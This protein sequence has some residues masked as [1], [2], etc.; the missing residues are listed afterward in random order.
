MGYFKEYWK[1]GEGQTE[2]AYHSSSFH[3]YFEGYVEQKQT[4]PRTGRAK[5]VRIYTAPYRVRCASDAQWRAAK[6]GTM[7]LYLSSAV[8]LILAATVLELENPAK[9][10]QLFVAGSLVC[11]FFLLYILLR[12]LSAPRKMTIG[13]YRAVYPGLYRIA[14]A[15]AVFTSLAFPAR[16][17]NWILSGQPINLKC[18][19]GLL[20]IAASGTSMLCL[21]LRE[22]KA[23]YNIEDNEHAEEN[24]FQVQR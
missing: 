9:Y 12:F 20:C 7:L 5:I 8:F 4:D 3:S 15:S 17:M 19:T 2:G 24:G 1:G 10:Y 11:D 21:F 14:L 23:V 22:K 18:I 6:L 16:L 13:D